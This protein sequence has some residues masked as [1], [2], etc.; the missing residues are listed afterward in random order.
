MRKRKL[1]LW[2]GQSKLHQA[3]T[4]TLCLMF[5]AV[6]LN[7]NPNHNPGCPAKERAEEPVSPRKRSKQ[8]RKPIGP[9]DRSAVPKRLA[10]KSQKKPAIETSDSEEDVPLKQRR[11]L[12]R[13]AAKK[14]PIRKY[15]TSEYEASESS[16][17]EEDVPLIQRVRA[18]AKKKPIDS[19]DTT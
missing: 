16:D 7:T 14:K 1:Q 10:T 6:F 11:D 15:E 17:S 2:I 9:R 13:R 3:L 8:T 12:R 4:L 18:A 19:K 5:A